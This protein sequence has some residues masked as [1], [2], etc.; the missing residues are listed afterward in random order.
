MQIL[1]LEGVLF[2]PFAGLR[3][4]AEGHGLDLDEVRGSQPRL[5]KNRGGGDMGSCL[6]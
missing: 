1:R 3:L 6:N 2:L 5:S 4:A